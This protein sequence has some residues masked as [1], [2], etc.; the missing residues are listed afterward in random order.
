MSPSHYTQ[1]QIDGFKRSWAKARSDQKFLII[2]FALPFVLYLVPQ[3]NAFIPPWAKWGL[4]VYAVAIIYF[5]S[6][7]SRCPACRK[8]I[9]EEFNPHFCPT[10]GVPLR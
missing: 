7:A 5:L 9:R 6:R 3:A 10:C 4:F 8:V 2:M 1:E